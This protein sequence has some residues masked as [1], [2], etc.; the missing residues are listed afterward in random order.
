MA[1]EVVRRI[2]TR[3]GVCDKLGIELFYAADGACVA[4]L[5]A[6]PDACNVYGVVDGAVL[7]A[8]ADTGMGLALLEA[9]DGRPPL[10]SITVTATYLRPA[11]PG[12][13]QARSCVVRLGRAV[14]FLACS[15]RDRQGECAPFS[16][17]FRVRTE[18]EGN[19]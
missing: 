17:V 6:E 9:L 12:C 16:G 13:L 18:R 19:P 8:M 10:S 7:F 15:I 1:D 11:A 5:D 14:T 2:T 3:D 4:T